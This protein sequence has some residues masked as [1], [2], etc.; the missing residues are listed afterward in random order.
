M[1]SMRGPLNIMLSEKHQSNKEYNT[2]LSLDWKRSERNNLEALKNLHL[3]IEKSALV[4]WN[5][6]VA[7][8]DTHQLSR[9]VLQPSQ[10]FLVEKGCVAQWAAAFVNQ[11]E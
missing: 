1:L 7:S 11:E 6:S 3:S 5:P 9:K 8:S 10:G 2:S 4:C